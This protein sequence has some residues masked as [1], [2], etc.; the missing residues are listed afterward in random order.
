MN[1]AKAVVVGYDTDF[2]WVGGSGRADEQCHLGI[3][4]FECS[5]VIS[6]CV[7]HV[8]VGG[9]VLAGARLDVEVGRLDR[10]TAFVNQS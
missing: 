3:V 7:N 10:P 1:D 9:T 5:P 2:E 4:G 8:V 6:N